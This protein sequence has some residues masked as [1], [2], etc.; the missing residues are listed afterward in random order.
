[1][2]I[3]LI[4]GVVAVFLAYECKGLLIGEG[5]DAAT[6][7]SIREF[8]EIDPD[9]TRLVRALTMHFGPHEVLLTME[10]EFLPD[11]TAAQVAAAIDRMDKAIRGAHPEVKHIFLEIQ[12][13]AAQADGK[14]RVDAGDERRG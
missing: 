10:V 11:L 7:E 9:V 1:M 2:L 3:G 6:R 12:S 4:L 14:P 5:V 8:V 13:I